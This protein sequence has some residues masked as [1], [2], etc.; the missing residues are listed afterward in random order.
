MNDIVAAQTEKGMC[1]VD[2]MRRDGLLLDFGGVVGRSWF[3][4][5][6]EIE[7]HLALPGGSLAWRGPLDPAADALWRTVLSGEIGESEYWRRQIAELAERIGRPVAAGELMAAICK[8][9]P[10]ALIRPE[11]VALIRK[12][13]SAGCRVAVL[14]NE[15]ERVYGPRAVARFAI[16]GELDAVV[17]GSATGMHKPSPEAFALGL[18]A[19]G[20]TAGQTVFVDDQPRNVAAA[21]ALGMAGVIFDIREPGRSFAEVM[22]LLGR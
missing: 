11:A 2:P 4:C 12:A 18:A 5:R 7:A 1:R 14:S 3:E 13:R 8:S 19:L 16:L 15:L 20:R 22:R 9:D 6:A 17:D 10:G 21:I